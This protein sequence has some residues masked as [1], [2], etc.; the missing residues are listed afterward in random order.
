[1]YQNDKRKKVNANGYQGEKQCFVARHGVHS[2]ITPISARREIKPVEV[3]KTIFWLLFICWMHCA[4]FKAH[5]PVIKTDI[6]NIVGNF[7]IGKVDILHVYAYG[8]FGTPQ[9]LQTQIVHG[10]NNQELKIQ[11]YNTVYRHKSKRSNVFG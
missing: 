4:A 8:L 6:Y 9:S 7:G 11:A 3:S 5:F 10:K 1:M 2:Y